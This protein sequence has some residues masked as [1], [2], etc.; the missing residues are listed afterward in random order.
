MIAGRNIPPDFSIE[1]APFAPARRNTVARP[2]QGLMVEMWQTLRIPTGLSGSE[3]FRAPIRDPLR[4]P[5]N[6]DSNQKNIHSRQ[7]V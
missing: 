7:H 3:I 4:E 5:A 2:K 6:Q 1:L